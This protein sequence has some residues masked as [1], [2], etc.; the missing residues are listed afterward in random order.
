[1]KK[2]EFLQLVVCRTWKLS[3]MQSPNKPVLKMTWS[4]LLGKNKI[5][6]ATFHE[7]VCLRREVIVWFKLRVQTCNGD[8]HFISIACLSH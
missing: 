8:F 1:M 4:P 6:M 7:F 3:S 2:L 5:R